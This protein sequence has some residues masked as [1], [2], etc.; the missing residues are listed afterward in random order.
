MLYMNIT[1]ICKNKELEFWPVE[2]QKLIQLASRPG[3]ASI[4]FQYA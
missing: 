1:R 4:L 2:E 3:N